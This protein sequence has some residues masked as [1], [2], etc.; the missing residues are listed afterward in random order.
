MDKLLTGDGGEGGGYGA[1]LEQNYTTAC[2]KAWSSIN[3]SMLSAWPSID[4]SILSGMTVKKRYKN[5]VPYT[6]NLR[7]THTCTEITDS[8]KNGRC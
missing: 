3:H 6:C 8:Y 1:E 2:K 7:K 5:V 4:H